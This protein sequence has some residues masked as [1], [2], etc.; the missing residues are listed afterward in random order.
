VI[1]DYS[2][3]PPLLLEPDPAI[4]TVSHMDPID[5]WTDIQLN[6]SATLRPPIT[7]SWTLDNANLPSDSRFQETPSQGYLR[8][9]MVT[10]DLGGMYMCTARNADDT[11]TSSVPYTLAVRVV[12]RK[13]LTYSTM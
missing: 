13:W 8:I 4:V 7:Y 12:E 10:P 9:A 11:V 5:A 3:P 1:N 2:S 6:C